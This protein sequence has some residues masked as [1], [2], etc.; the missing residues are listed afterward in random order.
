MIPFQSKRNQVYPSIYDGKPVVEKYFSDLD[1]WK[2]ES[3]HY[4]LLS[5]K[6][7][8]VKVLYREAGKL[9]ME[10]SPYPT[11]LDILEEQERT[12][13]ER[14]VW[15]HFADWL[16][17]CYALCGVL[18]TDK[19]LRNFLWNAEKQ[20]V[21]G[22]DL[23]GV[24]AVSLA[25]CGAWMIAALKTYDPPNT[26]VKQQAAEILAEKLCVAREKVSEECE[27]LACQR[28][29]KRPR[30]MSGVILAGGMSRRMG[31]NKAE[32]SL[33]GETLLERQVKKLR[34]LGIQDIL[35]SGSDD[36]DLP[37]V[38]KVCDVYPKRG[39][40]GGLHAALQAAKHPCC[41]VLS[42]DVPLIPVNALVHL[43]RSHTSGVTV[44]RCGAEEE[45]L[46]GIYD[47]DVSHAI[48]SLIAED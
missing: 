39:P 8:V 45:P 35:I 38:R 20:Q 34:A 33:M 10:Y 4:T 28:E 3:E 16:R 22:L 23:E 9:V 27:I 7:P 37:G 44:L 14:V 26:A 29:K 41:V 17:Q 5:E 30:Q 21:I 43:Q 31:K 40:L 15:E 25:Q 42:V 18:P 19:N 46:I 36:Q 13:F 47:R 32:L 12:G 1:D 24:A 2:R 6:I 11:L 48:E